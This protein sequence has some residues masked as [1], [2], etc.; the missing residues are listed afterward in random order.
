[1]QLSLMIARRSPVQEDDLL[2]AQLK[3]FVDLV[4]DTHIH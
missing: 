3:R 1:M 2:T 4:Q